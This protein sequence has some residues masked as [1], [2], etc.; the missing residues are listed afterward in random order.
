MK[1]VGDF[2]NIVLN[3]G[4]AYRAF[5]KDYNWGSNQYKSIYGNFFNLVEL[6]N[7][8]PSNN[9]LY[10][11]AA[12][13]YLHYIHGANPFNRTYLTNLSS[14]GADK[15][16][17]Q[18]YHSWFAD[19]SAWDTNPAPGFL[20]GGPNSSY[21]YDGCCPSGCGGSNNAKCTSESITPPRNQPPMKS[22]KDFNTSWPL[23][24][25]EVTENSNGYQVAYLR[26]LAKF[27]E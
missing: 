18:F 22:Y 11:Q 2:A 16:I 19:Q 17:T 4:S 3:N 5:I 8:D 9:L 13:S 20:A 12:E 6:H 27:V 26:L 1:N 7:I 23:N 15:Q 24:S 25:W 21:N 14:L 10:K